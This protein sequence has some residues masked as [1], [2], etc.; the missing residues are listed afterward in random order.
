[1]LCHFIR[2]RLEIQLNIEVEPTLQ[3]LE[4]SAIASQVRRVLEAQAVIDKVDVHLELDD[5]QP[6]AL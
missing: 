3:V 2:G 6:I 4:A 1:V 5:S